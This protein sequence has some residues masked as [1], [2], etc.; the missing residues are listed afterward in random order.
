ML[1][2]WA[3]VF[4]ELEADEGFEDLGV[5]S[6]ERLGLRVEASEGTGSFGNFFVVET[7]LNSFTSFSWQARRLKA[8][9]VL[10]RPDNHDE[11]LDT[12]EQSR[13]GRIHKYTRPGN[14]ASHLALFV[15]MSTFTG[16]PPFHG[17]KPL[18]T[19]TA[20]STIKS[21]PRQCR[22]SCSVR[23]V[24]CSKPWSSPVAAQAR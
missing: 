7:S 9:S 2:P 4:G 14:L 21:T 16:I 10:L 20:L 15:I 23:A 6:M 3:P 17:Q 18:R 19:T 24:A 13:P 22:R 11:E 8:E 5:S 12:E 1:F